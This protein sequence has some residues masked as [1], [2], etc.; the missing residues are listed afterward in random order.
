MSRNVHRKS[1]L[2][3]ALVLSFLVLLPVSE[4]M[5]GDSEGVSGYSIRLKNKHYD[6]SE[7]GEGPASAVSVEESLRT[8]DRP[9]LSSEAKFAQPRFPTYMILEWHWLLRI[10]SK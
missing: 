9:F 10:W 4:A 8:R 3:A 2:L 6:G 7:S 5:A 1:L